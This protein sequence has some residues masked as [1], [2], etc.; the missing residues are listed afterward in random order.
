MSRGNAI[1][2]EIVQRT[3]SRHF[4]GILALLLP[5]AAIAQTA[6]QTIRV[7]VPVVGSVVGANDVRWKTDIA[8][9]NDTRESLFIALQLPTAPDQPTVAFTLPPGATQKFTDVIGQAFSMQDALSPLLVETLGRR[10]VRVAASVYGIRGTDVTPR[11]PIPVEW[12][13]V[14][15]PLRTL[16]GLSFSDLFRTN[17]GLVNLG[18]RPASFTLGLQRIAGRNIAITRVSLPPNSLTHTP[19]QTLF[20]L[21]MKGD[22]FNVV[23]ETGAPNTYVY[24]SVIDNSTSEAHFIAP[25]VGAPDARYAGPTAQ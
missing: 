22:D 25:S 1:R 20:P 23:V 8:L 9:T 5:A 24:A 19:I 15:F 18:D 6:P 2:G 10:P 14:A 3:M 12:A 16:S 21:I 4:P 17:L 13:D 11:E 7:I